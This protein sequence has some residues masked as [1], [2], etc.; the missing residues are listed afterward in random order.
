VELKI[1]MKTY[2][3]RA[4]IFEYEENNSLCDNKTKLVVIHLENQLAR[5]FAMKMRNEL[6]M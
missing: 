5:S 2:N 6:K 3:R 4:M 1:A